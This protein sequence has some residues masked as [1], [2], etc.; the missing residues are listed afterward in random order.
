MKVTNLNRLS[1]LIAKNT[2][3]Y[4]LG[5]HLT[6]G[7]DVGGSLGKVPCSEELARRIDVL[8]VSILFTNFENTCWHTTVTHQEVEKNS[9]SSLS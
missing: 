5:E 4:V 3:D 7:V 6:V 9:Q 2:P 1:R 8:G